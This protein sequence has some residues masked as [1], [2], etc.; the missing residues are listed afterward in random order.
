MDKPVLIWTGFNNDLPEAQNLI[1]NWDWIRSLKEH[2][3]TFY[4]VGLDPVYTCTGNFDPGLFYG[5]ELSEIF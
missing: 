5:M 2:G 4:D 3:Y 1:N